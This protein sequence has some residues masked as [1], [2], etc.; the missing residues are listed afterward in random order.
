MKKILKEIGRKSVLWLCLTIGV[1]TGGGI[2]LMAARV[3][4]ECLLHGW[5]SQG[6]ECWFVVAGCEYCE[7]GFYYEGDDLWGYI[8][9]DLG[10]SVGPSG[11]CSGE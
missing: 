8:L 1:I 3:E 4:Q 2:S 11:F 7:S 9:Y 10:C 6:Q 5:N